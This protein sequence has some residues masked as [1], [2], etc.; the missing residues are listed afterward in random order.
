MDFS[1]VELSVVISGDR[2][3]GRAVVFPKRY[4]PEIKVVRIRRVHAH[5]QVIAQLPDVRF[6]RAHGSGQR[7]PGGRG[8]PGI[9]RPPDALQGAAVRGKADI[10]GAWAGGR[11]RQGDANGLLTAPRTVDE[12]PGI[13]RV[14]RAI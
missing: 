3:P 8:A 2:A 1:T 4:L 9:V 6:H 13:S 10:G 11:K 7:G 5:D 14:L 12:R